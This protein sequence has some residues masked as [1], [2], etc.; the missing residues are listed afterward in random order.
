MAESNICN[1]PHGSWDSHVHVVDVRAEIVAQTGYGAVFLQCSAY[2]QPIRGIHG[3]RFDHL[4]H[5]L[6]LADKHV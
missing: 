5:L 6:P 2:V 3:I 4:Y 1:L